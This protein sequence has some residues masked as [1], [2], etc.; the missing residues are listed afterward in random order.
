MPIRHTVVND[1]MEQII[2]GAKCDCQPNAA[3]FV[4]EGTEN[5]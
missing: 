4:W 1:P 2:L 3:R 5:K